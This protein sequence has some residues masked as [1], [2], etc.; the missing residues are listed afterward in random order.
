[1]DTLAAAYS[2]ASQFDRAV[3]IAE[4]ALQEAR[5]AGEEQLTKDIRTHLEFYR[6]K[7]PWRE[8]FGSDP[9]DKSALRE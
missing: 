3:R 5:D 8:S 9:L 6:A 2:E 1:M 7:R 4:R